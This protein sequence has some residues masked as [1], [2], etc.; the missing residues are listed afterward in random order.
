MS[1]VID[2]THTSPP[3]PDSRE[4]WRQR[5]DAGPHTA[6]FP[7]GAVLR[8]RIPTSGELLAAGVLPLELRDTVLLSL[9]HPE[10]AEGY[11]QDL[12][13]AAIVDP[14][15]N[16]LVTQAIEHGIALRDHL[17]AAMLVEPAVTAAEVAGGEYPEEDV[18]MLLEFAERRRDRDATG[19]RVPVI[20]ARAWA[21]FRDEPAGDDSA[22]DRDGD[23]R[24]AGAD[25]PDA[26]GGPV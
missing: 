14:H 22:R 23:G 17:V 6:T 2:A 9:G 13:A 19:A 3:A 26:D 21:R 8:F 10:G 16:E 25:V 20:V 18:K 12:V 1:Q 24:D 4:A 5:N 15:R 7:S 11:M